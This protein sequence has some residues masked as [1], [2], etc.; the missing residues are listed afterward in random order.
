MGD[1][2]SLTPSFEGTAPVHHVSRIIKLSGPTSVVGKSVVVHRDRD[3]PAAVT[4]GGSG[5][6][7]ACG[8]IVATPPT[9]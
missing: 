4:D 3:D 6:G 7:I 2:P 5:P 9:K 8:V 1:L